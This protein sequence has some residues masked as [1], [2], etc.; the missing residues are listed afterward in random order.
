[1]IDSTGIFRAL[2]TFAALF[3]LDVVWARYTAAVT[4]RR[5]TVASS[6]A[7]AIIALGAIGTISYIDDPRMIVPAMLG[8]F[9]GTFVGIKRNPS[10]GVDQ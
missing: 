5:R 1:M 3:A 8:A 9:C 4:D 7:A 6:Y 10:P 2:V